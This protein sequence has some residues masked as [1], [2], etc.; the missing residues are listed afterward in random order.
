[1]KSIVS[2]LLVWIFSLNVFAQ[3]NK[4][5]DLT[6]LKWRICLD[7][8]ATWANDKLFLT[9]EILKLPNNPPSEGWEMLEKTGNEITIPATVEEHYW[10]ENGYD[11][12]IT[13]DYIGVF[14]F[15]TQFKAKENWKGKRVLLHF[16]STR[17]RTEIYV[18]K[19]LAGYENNRLGMRI[20]N[21]E[22]I[23]GVYADRKEELYSTVVRIPVGIREIIISSLDLTK[24]INS[25]TSASVVAKKILQNMLLN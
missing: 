16:K 11:F 10:G 6:V 20:E 4:V 13:G 3:D 14:W 8:E 25:N 12:G 9:P 15:S 21:G 17:L 18:N 5:T 19:K 22:S 1:M 24:A 2:L 7:K 23:V